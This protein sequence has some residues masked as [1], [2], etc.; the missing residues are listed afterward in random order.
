MANLLVDERDVKF[1]LYEQLNIEELCEAE[2]YSETSREMFDMVLD[3][4]EKLAE[5]E[6]WPTNADGD[7]KGVTLED[8]QVRVP[9]SFHQAYRHLCEGGW[10]AL[11]VD[12]DV[13]GQ[14]FPSHSLS[15]EVY[16]SEGVESPGN[17]QV[18]GEPP[19]RGGRHPGR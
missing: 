13:G 6:I 17:P 10:A 8:G 1:V 19:F 3:A 4:A 12:P 2:M 7:K 5:R 16:V 14:G 9:E 18:Q 11:A 15:C